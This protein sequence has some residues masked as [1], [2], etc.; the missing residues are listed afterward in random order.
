MPNVSQPLID[1]IS[2]TYDF[3]TQTGEGLRALISSSQNDGNYQLHYVG[4]RYRGESYKYNWKLNLDNRGH[5]YV[6]IQMQPYITA[7]YLK[8]EWNPAKLGAAVNERLWGFLEILLADEYE[9]FLNAATV[10][11]MDIAVDVS[12]MTPDAIWIESTHLTKG[13]I[14]TGGYGA[15]HSVEYAHVQTINLGD[16]GS[17]TSFCIYCRNPDTG[18]RISTNPFVTRIEAR[19][20]PRCTL[21]RLWNIPNPFDR[22]TVVR[23]I[24]AVELN[25]ATDMQRL[26]IASCRSN[27]LQGAHRLIRNYRTRTRM[28][29][30]INQNIAENWFDPVQIWSGYT[31]SLRILNVPALIS[32]ERMGAE[33][34]WIRNRRRVA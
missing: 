25:S 34:C 1:K 2:I 24:D 9:P 18:K 23:S 16:R 8:L 12:P 5:D 20:K 13:G 33:G 14:R 10:T 7:G 32:P 28:K 11:R 17:R 4:S 31:Q 6:L 3:D 27:G 22:L 15:L 26:F 19:V 21:R 29:N 30:W